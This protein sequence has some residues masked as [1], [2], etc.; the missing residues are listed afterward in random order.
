MDNQSQPCQSHVSND[1]V[2]TMVYD[3]QYGDK[4]R[5]LIQKDVEC[6]QEPHEELTDTSSAA[7]VRKRFRDFMDEPE[8][9][10]KN[11]I[12]KQS[13][14]LEVVDVQNISKSSEPREDNDEERESRSKRRRRNAIKPN[15]MTQRVAKDVADCYHLEKKAAATGTRKHHICLH[16][17]ELIV[18]VFLFLRASFEC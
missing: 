7:L 13:S 17:I 9:W 2:S 16:I 3:Q 4:L 12:P 5:A 8:T 15:S 10:E 1:N 14:S 11:L 18:R 6:G